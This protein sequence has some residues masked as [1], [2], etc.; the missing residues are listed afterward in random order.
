MYLIP[1]LHD[2]NQVYVARPGVKLQPFDKQADA[3]AT[4]PCC[5]ILKY[6]CTCMHAHT[7]TYKYT[8]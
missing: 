4:W 6:V 1:S 2:L 8:V 3:P 5:L 7:H